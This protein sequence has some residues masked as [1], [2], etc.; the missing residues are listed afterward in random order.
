MSII[1]YSTCRIQFI[2][3]NKAIP[4]RNYSDR[5]TVEIWQSENIT[6]Y[7]LRAIDIENNKAV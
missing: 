5:S 6:D 2:P 3:N 1:I 4:E 7:S